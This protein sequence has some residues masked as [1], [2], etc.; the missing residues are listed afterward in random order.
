MYQNVIEKQK[1][2]FKKK[3]VISQSECVACGSCVNVC[4]RGAITI[5]HGIYAKV[6]DD[7]CIGCGKCKIACPASIIKVE[8]RDNE[9]K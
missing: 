5:I 8:V 3:A 2:R 4:P 7:L 9:E 6:N 1:R